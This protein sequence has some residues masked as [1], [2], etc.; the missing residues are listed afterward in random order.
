[1]KTNTKELMIL[2]D[3][4]EFEFNSCL[5]EYYDKKIPYDKVMQLSD[6]HREVKHKFL[7]DK[8]FVGSLRYTDDSFLNKEYICNQF[9][10]FIHHIVKFGLFNFNV[11]TRKNDYP[12]IKI[13]F[14][15][16]TSCPR[17]V[18]E[19][20]DFKSFN[21]NLAMYYFVMGYND[22]FYNMTSKE[23]EGQKIWY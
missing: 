10:T 7:K 1:M 12:T 14:N 8:F 6:K 5:Q 4:Q 13:H 17:I 21:N 9:I 15:C 22:M 3:T 23:R 19:S 18:I 20:S 2:L 11:S 16:Q